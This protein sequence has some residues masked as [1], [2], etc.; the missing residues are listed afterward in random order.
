MDRWHPADP[1]ADPYNPNTVWVPGKYALTGTT[2]DVN[3][4]FNIQDAS[5][6]RLKSAEIGYSI[7]PNFAKI[8]GIKGARI[9]VNGYNILTFTGL[10]Y[11]DPEHPSSTYGYLY[12]LNKTFSLG[13]NVKL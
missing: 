11:L 12:P 7:S 2:A 1:N 5:Y 13:V 4:M 10:K 6:V 9:F 8:I 3:S